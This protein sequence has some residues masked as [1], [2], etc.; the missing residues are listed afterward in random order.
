MK[1]LHQMRLRRQILAVCSTV[2]MGLGLSLTSTAVLAQSLPPA[3]VYKSSTCGCCTEYVKYLRAQGMKVTAIDHNN[4][5][6]NRQM[7]GMKKQKPPSERPRNE[8]GG[9]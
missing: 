8:R 6:S 4:I 5:I 7:T 9:A 3:T 2:A 1:S